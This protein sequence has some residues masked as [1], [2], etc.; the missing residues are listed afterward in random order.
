MYPPQNGEPPAGGPPPM[1]G[2]GGPP[3]GPPPEPKKKSRAPLIIGIVA[4]VVLLCCGGSTIAY[5]VTD[6][7]KTSGDASASGG[8]TASPSSS[9]SEEG[10]DGDLD[11]YHNGDCLTVD[12]DNNVAPAK[13]TD[14]GAY[15]V[16]L[17]KDGT[18]SDSYCQD[19]DATTSLY[20]D[21]E[22]STAEDF[23]LCIGPASDG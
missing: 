3:Y 22:G 18:I 6:G 10:V 23:V 19:T 14:P 1:P 8:V 12:G 4:G 7:G 16:L 9:A 11:R 5:F 15:K 2:P 20:Q 13:C 17:R 21:V